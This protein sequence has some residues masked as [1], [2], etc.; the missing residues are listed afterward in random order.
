M[1]LLLAIRSATLLWADAVEDRVEPITDP[2]GLSQPTA[3]C[4]GRCFNSISEIMFFKY[5][6][7]SKYRSIRKALRTT[8]DF[9]LSHR[10][11]CTILAACFMV[12]HRMGNWVKGNWLFSVHLCLQWF[13]KDS[14]RTNGAARLPNASVTINTIIFPLYFL[15]PYFSMRR[16]TLMSEDIYKLQIFKQYLIFQILK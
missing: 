3:R 12:P 4:H 11:L 13:Y 6:V 5:L 8:T 16:S 9:F 7:V 10:S 1:N 14:A 15:I 2:E